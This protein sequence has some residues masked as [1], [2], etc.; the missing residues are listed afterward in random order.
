MGPWMIVD[1]LELVLLGARMADPAFRE[2]A[3]N[4]LFN[5]ELATLVNSPDAKQALW[6]WLAQRGVD[7]IGEEKPLDAIVR[8]LTEIQKRRD[9]VRDLIAELDDLKP[10]EITSLQLRELRDKLRLCKG[11]K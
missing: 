6:R 3:G 2:T 8:V 5:G 9:Y 10:G 7:R 1:P 4:H 11:T